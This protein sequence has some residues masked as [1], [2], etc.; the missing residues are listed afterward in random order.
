MASCRNFGTCEGLLLRLGC[1]YWVWRSLAAFGSSCAPAWCVCV[2]VCIFVYVCVRTRLFI[3]CGLGVVNT[4]VHVHV[5]MPWSH[6]KALFMP[7]QDLCPVF[8]QHGIVCFLVSPFVSWRVEIIV[9]R[10][11]YYA[12]TVPPFCTTPLTADVQV[13]VMYT[14]PPPPPPPPPP[15]FSLSCGDTGSYQQLLNQSF[16]TLYPHETLSPLKSNY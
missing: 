10:W 12:I 15:P 9:D 16:Q 2:C 11:Q 6:M 1:A 5:C 13:Q 8:A 14:L 4:N 7:L 3:L